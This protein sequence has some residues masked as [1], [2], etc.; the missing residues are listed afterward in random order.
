MTLGSV[1]H[2]V[3]QIQGEHNAD[4]P[5]L[6]NLR[7]IDA[8]QQLMKVT[9]VY[10]RH[11]SDDGRVTNSIL[12]FPD[13]K[14]FQSHTGGLNAHSTRSWIVRGNTF[15]NIRS[16][17]ASLAGHAIHFWSGAENTIVER[18]V[19]VNSDRGIGLGLGDRGHEGGVI[20]NNFVHVV[21]DVGIGLKSSLNTYVAHN[22]VCDI[23]SPK[24]DRVPFFEDHKRIHRT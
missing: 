12:E 13:G 8:S 5:V 7:I 17:D 2:H 4:R 9:G 1:K 16:P 23:K 11:R 10:T 15:R 21:C 6:Q 14:A 20:K 22:T 3:I 19:I 24:S 18:N